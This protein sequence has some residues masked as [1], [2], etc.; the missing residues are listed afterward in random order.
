MERREGFK[1]WLQTIRIKKTGKPIPEKTIEGYM[2]SIHRLSD[3]MYES[4]VISKRLYS[5]KEP[6]EVSEAIS[7]IKKERLYL[8]MNISNEN[9]VHKALDYYAEFIKAMHTKQLDE[10]EEK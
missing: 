10:A 2:R 8:E 5:M 3:A 4:G 1:R 9:S 6:E 7:K